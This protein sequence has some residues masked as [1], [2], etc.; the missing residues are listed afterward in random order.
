MTRSRGATIRI[1]ALAG[2]LRLAGTA[3]GTFR[4]PNRSGVSKHPPDSA[5]PRVWWRWM[6]G[7]VIKEGIT[8]DLEDEAGRHRRHADVW[9]VRTGDIVFGEHEMNETRNT[10]SFG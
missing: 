3:L 5:K 2:L 9:L 7:N 6:S 10:A 4:E 1:F 8:A